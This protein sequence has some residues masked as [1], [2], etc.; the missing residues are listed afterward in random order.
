M[1]AVAFVMDSLAGGLGPAIATGSRLLQAEGWEVSVLAP[2]PRGSEPAAIAGTFIPVDVPASG[3]HLVSMIRAGRQI[4]R[5]LARE[6]PDIVHCHGL[7]CFI[8]TR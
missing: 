8:L 1:P 6:R 2:A 3:R 7:R 5:A 4:A